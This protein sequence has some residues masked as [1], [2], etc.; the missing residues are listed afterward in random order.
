MT[1]P[2]HHP[3]PR[4]VSVLS[5]QVANQI[6]AGE[7][8]ERPASVVKE[9]VENSLDA[10]AKRITITIENGGRDLIRVEDD[11]AGMMRADALLS[12]ERHATSKIQNTHDLVEIG[13]LGFRGEALPSI[14]SVSALELKTK[15][16]GELSGT[17]VLVRGGA[18]ELVEDSGMAAGT[19]V[20]VRELFF[21]IES[22]LDFLKTSATEARYIT[23]MIT[24]IAL[25]HPSVR[26]RL[27]RDG[28]VIRDL[29]AVDQLKD[30][31][32]E[33]LGRE[34][35]DALYPLSSSKAIE[36]VTV[37]GFFSKP[38]HVQRSARGIYTFVN[39]RYVTEPTI[40]AAI[41]KAYEPLLTKNQH[42]SVVLFIDVP[43]AQIDINVHP[44]KTEVR[45]RDTQ[46]IFQ[47]V[48]HTLANSITDS[49]W[50]TEPAR[51]GGPSAEVK[52]LAGSSRATD[53]GV[54]AVG[55]PGAS[56]RR[57]ATPARE[58][59]VNAALFER[60]AGSKTRNALEPHQI[61]FRPTEH[62]EPPTVA[63]DEARLVPE[64]PV[65]ETDLFA[66]QPGAK[67]A[68]A[69]FS[70][71]RVI[72]ESKRRYILCEDDSSLV[73][74][75]RQAILERLT[76]EELV[77]AYRSASGEPKN[78]PFPK[79]VEL[80]PKSAKV[81]STHLDLFARMGWVVEHFGESSYA[82]KALPR[83]LAHV[84][85]DRLL[86]SVLDD[87]SRYVRALD[88]TSD[89]EALFAT[90]ASHVVV[91]DATARAHDVLFARMDELGLHR[92]EPHC[93]P[94]QH[95]ID[96]AEIGQFFDRD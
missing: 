10:G 86:R 2:T 80:E 75:D 3:T 62:T 83:A 92:H 33:L 18:R 55:A 49:P 12:L 32:L 78:L 96:F 73:V 88:A 4:P 23:D 67:S 87:L 15:P 9:L 38:G 57:S 60:I 61:N 48:Y 54:S 1:T 53:T 77:V 17:R 76:F 58:T 74:L 31:I 64:K 71:L 46:P 65:D 37:R 85:L 30:R 7:V 24:R 8:V 95:K 81:M 29:P 13:T 72:G 47:V 39:D 43:P 19:V 51:P 90:M 52:P 94:I 44:A 16:H 93:R 69:Y 22:R 70:T 63:H 26:F 28:K 50:R 40:R 6:A 79:R 41:R 59:F 36:G 14:A 45:F 21:N 91:R 89:I 68:S 20:E 42:P 82:I 84:D 25:T 27:V 34:V 56:K 5:T 35:Y 66:H 11:G